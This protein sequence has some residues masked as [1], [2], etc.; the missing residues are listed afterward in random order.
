MTHKLI[1]FVVSIGFVFAIA[2]AGFAQSSVGRSTARDTYLISAKAGGVNLT[3][4]N[5]GIVRAN[6]TSGRLLKGDEIS[7]G[8][9]VST[10]NNGRAEILLN[11]GSFIRIGGNTAFEFR[12]TSL[13]DLKIMIDRGSAMFEVYATREFKVTLITPRGKAVLVESGIYRVDVADN[14]IAKLAVWNGLA[15]VN[16]RGGVAVKKGRVATIDKTVSVVEKFDRDDKDALALWSKDRGKLVAR[17]TSRLKNQ[18]V[19]NSLISAYNGGRWGMYDAFGVWVYDAAFGSSCFL[20]F[21]RGWYSPYGYGFGHSLWWYDLPPVI[22][23]PPYVPAMPDRF[24]KKPGSRDAENGGGGNG[25]V[26]PPFVRIEETS[27]QN[28]PIRVPNDP[29]FDRTPNS[30]PVYFPPV[31]APVSLPSSGGDTG[32]KTRP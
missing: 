15:E 7:I 8:D 27:R 16:G 12:S 29:T 10:D 24:G 23:Y 21:G 26:A 1:R 13:D 30:S 17:N 9:R 3:E 2:T 4:G 20:P 25:G 32:S 22:Y 28:N 11:P 31:S 19:R 18:Q 6:K 14:G 5:V